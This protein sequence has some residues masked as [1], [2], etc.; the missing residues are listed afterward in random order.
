M[1]DKRRLFAHLFPPPPPPAVARDRWRSRSAP[2]RGRQRGPTSPRSSG[3]GTW[4]PARQSITRSWRGWATPPISNPSIPK[5]HTCIQ[6]N[7]RESSR[8][9]TTNMGGQECM[10]AKS[11]G[12]NESASMPQV[13]QTSFRHQKAGF[14]THTTQPHKYIQRQGCCTIIYNPKRKAGDHCPMLR[15]VE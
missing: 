15:K 3:S 13:T 12:R 7:R 14:G 8:R 9:S 1:R 2:A 5:R 10:V 11:T 4:P 6:K